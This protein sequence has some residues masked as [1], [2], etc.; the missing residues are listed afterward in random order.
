VLLPLVI[1]LATALLAASV[2]MLIQGLIA[3][4]TAEAARH[5]TA[6]QTLASQSGGV[7]TAIELA[8]T[9]GIS[10]RRADRI[11]RALVDDVSFTVGIDERLGVL[12][13][14]YPELLRQASIEETGTYSW[15]R[16]ASLRRPAGNGARA[17]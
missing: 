4:R 10:T 16:G 2:V 1:A 5:A 12:Q 14:W 3:R 8:R 15:A 11:L 13:Y 6:V 17:S 9:L 7:V